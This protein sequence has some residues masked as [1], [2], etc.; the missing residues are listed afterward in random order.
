MTSSHGSPLR[1]PAPDRVA[2]RLGVSRSQL[3]E[4]HLKLEA[5]RRRTHEISER[6]RELEARRTKAR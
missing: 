2:A 5:L 1:P 4:L 3:G 6:L